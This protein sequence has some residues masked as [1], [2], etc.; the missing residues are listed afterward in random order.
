MSEEDFSKEPY[1]A[2]TYNTYILWKSLPTFLK[3]QPRVSLEKFGIDEEIIFE[4][5]EIKTQAGFGKKYNVDGGTLTDWNKRI[6]KDGLSKSINSWAR[7]L[8]PNVV[9]ALYKNIT[10]SGRA[11]EV[12][13]WY[14]LIEH[15]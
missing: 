9:F 4:L 1:K 11:H 10:K 15:D 6:Q 2:Q 5:L 8:T 12:R 7:K 3:G 14:E 13:A